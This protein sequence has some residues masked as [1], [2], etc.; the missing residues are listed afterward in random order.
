MC[1]CRRTPMPAPSHLNSLISLCAGG[2][3]F[4]WG[5][6]A[7]VVEKTHAAE[8]EPAFI[9][10]GHQGV[11]AAVQVRSE[12][13][14][15]VRGRAVGE[16][17]AASGRRRGVR[18]QGPDEARRGAAAAEGDAHCDAVYHRWEFVGFARGQGCRASR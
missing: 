11:G 14:R 17:P 2:C 4:D 5:V 6:E 10:G 13:L 16:R 7:Q 9:D 18:L 12:A 8:V 15:G 3:A 1:G